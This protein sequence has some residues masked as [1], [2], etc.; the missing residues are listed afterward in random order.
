MQKYSEEQGPFDVVVVYAEPCGGE[1]C[2]RPK[3]VSFGNT[4]AR[5]EQMVDGIRRQRIIEEV[6]GTIDKSA[7]IKVFLQP[8]VAPKGTEVAAL[9]S[10]VDLLMELLADKPATLECLKAMQREN[11][12]AREIVEKEQRRFRSLCNRFNGTHTPAPYYCRV[13]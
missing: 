6:R 11:V 4:L 3:V 1:V 13:S 5:A 9:K 2:R 8:A 10:Q 12:R 7:I